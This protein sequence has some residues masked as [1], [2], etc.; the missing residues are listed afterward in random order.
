MTTKG[1]RKLIL[2]RETLRVLQTAELTAING[3]T[4]PSLAVT[5]ELV[6]AS[7]AAYITSLRFCQQIAQFSLQQAQGGFN[8]MY[9]AWDNAKKVGGWIWDHL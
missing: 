8:G 9:K 2:K 3:G 5:P 4:T 1:P 6:A 7:E